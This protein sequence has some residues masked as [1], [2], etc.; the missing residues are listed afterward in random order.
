MKVMLW[1]S[2]EKVKKGRQEIA[3]IRSLK[4]SVSVGQST[5]RGDKPISLALHDVDDGK[6]NYSGSQ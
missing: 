3:K 6:W 4:V 1:L 5:N 2:I